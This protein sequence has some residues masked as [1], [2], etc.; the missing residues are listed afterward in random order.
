MNRRDEFNVFM[1]LMD[2]GTY[3][4]A[5]PDIH[6]CLE[7]LD[8]VLKTT[9]AWRRFN[10][11]PR[12]EFKYVFLGDYID[13]GPNSTGVVMRVKEYVEKFDAIV[14]LGNHD[15][16]L[17]GTGDMSL[18]QFEDGRWAYQSYLWEINGGAQTCEEMFGKMYTTDE[19]FASPVPSHG[20][21]ETGMDC[22][23]Y[24]TRIVNS[25][26]Y[27]FLKEHGKLYHSTKDIF[28]CHAPQSR[29]EYTDNSLVWGMRTDY[30][31]GKGD[32]CFITPD[33]KKISVHGHFHRLR[34]GVNFT[35]IHNYFH[36]GIPKKVILAD[37]GCG[38][39][40]SGRLHPVIVKEYNSSK[41]PEVIAIL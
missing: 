36:G 27:K 12:D 6:G 32:A 25:E 37:S 33:D 9:E 2:K 28:F 26:V 14:L 18:T 13:R 24:R 39:G 4:V 29:K 21:S 1:Q 19:D 40:Q 8:K 31:N 20:L 23:I 30:S 11:I 5:I 41:Y 15:M 34:E 10:K 7:E 3:Y 17:I 16:F 35:R 38:C 22:N